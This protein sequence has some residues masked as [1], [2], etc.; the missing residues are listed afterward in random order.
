[1]R[2]SLSAR[3]VQLSWR[4]YFQLTCHREKGE[5]ME[6]VYTRASVD[7]RNHS[8]FSNVSSKSSHFYSFTRNPNH[9]GE[10]VNFELMASIRMRSCKNVSNR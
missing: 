5:R 1:M 9:L 2:V 3:N 6:T 7:H 10:S 4:V 8:P